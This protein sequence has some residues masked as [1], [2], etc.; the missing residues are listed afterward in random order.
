MSDERVERNKANWRRFQLEMIA[1]KNLDLLDELMAPEMTVHRGPE[2]QTWTREKF[3]EA[4]WQFTGRQEESRTIDAI[5]GEG[6]MIW[7][8]WTINFL[9]SSP[10]HGLEPTGM[11]LKSEEWGQIRFDEEG[12]VAEGWFIFNPMNIYEQAGAKVH[13][14][15]PAEQ[16]S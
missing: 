15:Q 13:I 14:E 9:H 5:G 12:R 8:R 1:G 16:S 6:D 11:Q 3:R 10:L 7:A 4:Y 2:P